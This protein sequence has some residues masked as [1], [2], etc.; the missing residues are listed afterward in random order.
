MVIQYSYHS[1]YNNGVAVRDNHHGAC[2]PMKLCIY[3]H[4]ISTG[5]SNSNRNGY[6]YIYYELN[7]FKQQC[8]L[9]NST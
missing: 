2:V 7:I 1:C 4:Y 5:D 8:V 6:L 3:T 9:M